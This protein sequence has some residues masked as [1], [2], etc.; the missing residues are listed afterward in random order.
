MQCRAV[1]TL[2]AAERWESSHF[3]H[4]SLATAAN[5]ILT[6]YQHEAVNHQPRKR[7]GKRVGE[8][9]QQTKKKKKIKSQDNKR[10]NEK[11][12]KNKDQ[13]CS[14]TG[15]VRSSPANETACKVSREDSY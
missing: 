14:I 11:D 3:L 8:C 5:C 10:G 1:V 9:F 4:A 6:D 12:K 7:K 2:H 13:G 15:K